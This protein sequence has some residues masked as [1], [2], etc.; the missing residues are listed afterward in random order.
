MKY[1]VAL[2]AAGAF[3]LGSNV[4]QGKENPAKAA[5]L[6]YK[7][8]RDLFK[9]LEK[10]HR[11]AKDVLELRAQRESGKFILNKEERKLEKQARKDFHI[12]MERIRNNTLEVLAIY[13]RE[14]GKQ[15][16]IDPLRKIFGK[17]L[18][19]TVEVNWDEQGLDEIVDELIDGYGVKMYIKGDVDVR[20]TMS[21]S[22]KMTLLSILLQVENVFDAKLI[23]RNDTLWF[24]RVKREEKE[25]A[26]EEK[27]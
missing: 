26:L 19:A 15:A 14:L 25:K 5:K 1:L 27:D 2:L 13:D 18:Y 17:A 22:G 3:F 10:I 8:Q 16:Y 6:L 23:Y 24:V 21:L 7:R 11:A 20:R 4:V 12:F 9:D